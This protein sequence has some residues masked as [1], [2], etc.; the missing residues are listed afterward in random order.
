MLVGDLSQ[1]ELCILAYYLQEFCDDRTMADGIR[2]GKDVHT[3]NTE[4]WY[5]IDEGDDGF[6]DKRK[7]AKNGIFSVNYDASPMRVSLTLN[8]SVKEA[9]EINSAVYENTEIKQLK[10]LFYQVVETLRD[11]KPLQYRSS[12][13]YNGFFYDCLGVR[14]FYP[15]ISSRDVKLQKKARRR[16]F[17]ALLQGGCFSLFAT[18]LLK[19]LPEMKKRGAWLS[20]AVHDEAVILVPD[21][22]AE[23]L[24]A[25]CQR[26]FTYMLGDVPIRASFKLVNNWS[27][28]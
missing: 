27:E 11:I 23:E 16:S 17:N 13:Y 12:L 20:A 2:E 8:I 26:D 7:I 15:E 19:L 5:G 6:N 9:E 1:I 14:Y 21:A 18:L 28:K 24:L 22:Y 25:I 10:E 4:N 3:A